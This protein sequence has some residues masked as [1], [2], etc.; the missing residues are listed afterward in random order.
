MRA[1]EQARIAAGFPAD[2]AALDAI[3]AQVIEP[4]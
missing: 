2:A 3:A 1:A 4:A